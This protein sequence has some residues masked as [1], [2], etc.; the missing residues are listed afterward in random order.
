MGAHSV[1]S[2]GQSVLYHGRVSTLPW[3]S[4]E[5]AFLAGFPRG[6][7]REEGEDVTRVISKSVSIHIR[8]NFSSLDIYMCV[9]R[10]EVEEGACSASQFQ[11]R[12]VATP[13]QGTPSSSCRILVGAPGVV[14]H[15]AATSA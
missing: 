7:A 11:Q 6:P 9:G 1:L 3:G 14:G 5:R 4:S 2:S 12:S 8:L 10:S 15:W 13:D